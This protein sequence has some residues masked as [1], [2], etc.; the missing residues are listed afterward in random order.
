MEKFENIWNRMNF[1]NNEVGRKVN[2]EEFFLF[3]FFL[4][5]F[6]GSGVEFFEKFLC[7]NLL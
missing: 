7:N 4:S 3:N 5:I 2:M 1:Y 6:N